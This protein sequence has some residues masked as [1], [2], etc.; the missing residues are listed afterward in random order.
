MRFADQIPRNALI[1]LI[2]CQF[3]VVIPHLFHLPVWIIL[4]YI[5]AA[6]WRLQMYRGRAAMPGRWARMLLALAAGALIFAS[7]RTFIGLE[8]MVGLLLVATALKLIETVSAKDGYV[9]AMLGFFVCVTQFLF[10]QELPMVLYGVVNTMLLVAALIA[11][12]ELPGRRFSTAVL[13]SSGK[14][15]LQAVPMMVIL[16]VVFPRIGPLWS[17]PSKDAGGVTGMSDT[18]RPGEVSKLGRSAAVA[19]RAR[20]DG[21]IPPSRELYWRGVV[22][23]VFED[24]GWRSLRWD[25]IP[26]WDRSERVGP[27]GGEPLSYQV[28]LEP[29]MQ[30]WLFAL[31][32]ARSDDAKIVP[33]PDFRL[34]SAAPVESQF[35]Y[36]VESYPGTVLEP[37]LRSWRRMTE[38]A[39]PEAENPRTRAL[40]AELQQRYPE[41]RALVQA[42]LSYFRTEPFYYTLEPPT[43]DADDFVDRFLFNSRR[44]FCEHYAYS[45][46]VMMRQA[47]IPARVVGG[48]QGGETNPLNNT[49]IVRQFDAHAWAEVWLE[50]EGWQRVDPTAAVSPARVEFG[51]E[52]A[53]ADEGSFL[54][55]SPLSAFRYRNI[56]LVNWL[57]LRY[58]ALAWQWQAFIVGFDSGGQIDFLKRWFGEIRVSWFVALMLGSWAVVLIPLSLW[59]LRV[60]RVQRRSTEEL[61]FADLS[62]RLEKRGITRAV[63]EAP[64]SFMARVLAEL[65]EEGAGYGEQLREV[66]RE[67]YR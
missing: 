28:I 6:L 38:L 11:L 4:V 24:G 42:V 58:D 33:A 18:L 7:F 54:A 61:R 63:G 36:R 48:Y 40:V 52:A 56:D 50:G 32:F 34:V 43:L 19:F 67:L 3:T 22:M 16:F 31:P 37:E 13:G 66:E 10:S 46:V 21:A 41:P 8:P 5:G 15:L 2:I 53:L 64:R 26:R 49:V 59:M 35:G 30:R 44:G 45:F 12:N 14:L 62:R 39:F 55:D 20:F 47:G 27:F 60:R 25:E 1:W 17:V 23:S 57:R 65:G 51:L 9:L 29:T